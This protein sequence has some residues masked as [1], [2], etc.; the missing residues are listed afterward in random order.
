MRSTRGS[1]GLS[2]SNSLSSGRRNRGLIP[3]FEEPLHGGDRDEHARRHVAPGSERKALECLDLP[4]QVVERRVAEQMDVGGVGGKLQRLFIRALQKY[5]RECRAGERI[6]KAPALHFEEATLVIERLLAM[7]PARDMQELGGTR[8]VVGIGARRDRRSDPVDD[9][10]APLRP[11]WPQ[12][13]CLCRPDRVGAAA[14]DAGHGG[15]CRGRGDREDRVVLRPALHPRRARPARPQRPVEQHGR[16]PARSGF[17]DRPGDRRDA[18]QPWRAHDRLPRGGFVPAEL[19]VHPAPV[20]RRPARAGPLMFAE[21]YEGARDAF[22][23]AIAALGGRL[24][25]ALVPGKGVRG[26]PLTIDWAVI[27]PA[28]APNTLL[29]ISGVHGAEGHAG[30]AAQRAFAAALD[31]GALGDDRNVVMI[32]ALNP[33]GLSHGHRV[34]ADN[35]DLSRNFGDFDATPLED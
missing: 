27:G 30:S 8:A 5:R 20:R 16:R 28:A 22:R 17:G 15:L 33:W 12:C 13:P 31:P 35:V 10:R 11:A 23:T 24:E 4:A 32:H 1:P 19:P 34:D 7:Y 2:Q 3:D 14:R 26:E 18:G 6:G 25:S 29:S 9:R 21:S